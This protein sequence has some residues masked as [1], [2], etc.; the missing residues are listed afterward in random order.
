MTNPSKTE[1]IVILDRSGSM[2][3]IKNDMQGGFTDVA[4]SYG[5]A[6]QHAVAFS[7]RAGADAQGV[8]RG[9]SR[10]FAD[11]RTG[12]PLKSMGE[13]YAQSVAEAKSETG[14]K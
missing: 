13:Y 8:M 14:E 9:M 5:I 12:K 3:S 7:A 4:K 1:I 10:N 6:A 11:A 2:A